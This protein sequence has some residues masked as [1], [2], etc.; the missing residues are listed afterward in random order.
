MLDFLY[1][2]LGFILAVGILV[3]IHEYGHFIFARALGV[4]VL[5]FSIGFGKKITSLYDKK[6]TEFAI[7]AIPLGGYV[8]MLDQNESTVAKADLDKAF[9]TKPLWARALIVLAGPLFNFIFAIVVYW[10]LFM[11]GVSTLAPILGNIPKGSPAAIADLHRGAEIIAI[12]G[13]M[14]PTWEDVVLGVASHAGEFDHMQVKVKDKDSNVVTDHTIN[15]TS[16]DIDANGNLLES[17]GFVPFDPTQPVV[18]GVIDD[19]PAQKAGLQ[20]GDRIETINGVR[21]HNISQMMQEL[22]HKANQPVEL[23]YSRLGENNTITITPIAKELADGSTS[24][25]IGIEFAKQSIPEDLLR[26]THYN[27]LQALGMSIQK[28]Y[29]YSILTLQFLGKMVLG[30]IS[31]QHI[32]GPISIAQYAGITVRSGVESFISFMA[33]VSLSLGVI[34]LLPIPILDGGHLLFCVIEAVRGKAL[35]IRAMNIGIIFGGVILGAV[36]ILAIY[37]DILRLAY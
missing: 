6:G 12:D 31:T 34:N 13:K 20:P 26:V 27:P 16:W 37:N 10:F 18:G 23:T 35:S 8:K 15:L 22:Q 5:R 2:I 3:I 7:C 24:G 29:D 1:A 25:F 32:S 30:K 21:I 14:T 28:T 36:I 4:K 9:N 17:I 19:L 11:W 33:L